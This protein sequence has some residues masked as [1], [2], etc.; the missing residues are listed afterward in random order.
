MNKFFKEAKRIIV[1]N[2]NYSKHY[3]DFCNSFI[4]VTCKD[5]NIRVFDH[6]SI[7]SFK[8]LLIG[9]DNLEEFN[10][11]LVIA[12]SKLTK[13]KTIIKIQNAEQREKELKESEECYE[14]DIFT[15]EEWQS[16]L[17][18]YNSQKILMKDLYYSVF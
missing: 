18:E 13:E 15:K 16:A 6:M 8:N 3:L 1:E 4:D 7:L 2:A 12:A 14:D 10:N 17:H 9:V 11:A 5:V